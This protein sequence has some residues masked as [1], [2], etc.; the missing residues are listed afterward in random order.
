MLEEMLCVL[1]NP[2]VVGESFAFIW[3]QQLLRI[4]VHTMDGENFQKI[5]NPA[6][7][8]WNPF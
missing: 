4:L 6:Y 3:N 8:Q 1:E 5:P 2:E 7:F